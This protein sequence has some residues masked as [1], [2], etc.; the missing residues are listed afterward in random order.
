M[1]APNTLVKVYTA[2][3]LIML[4]LI[5]AAFFTPPDFPMLPRQIL[6]GVWGV[7][8]TLVAERWL[9]SRTWRQAG[10]AVGFVRTRLPAVAVA[11]LVSLP[12]WLFLPLLAWLQATPIQLQPDWFALLLGVMLVNGLTEE[13][14][15]RG[16][17]FGHLQQ[18]HSFSRAATLS[19]LLFAAQHLYLIFTIGWLAGLASVVLAAL[20]TFPLA[21]SY[22]RGGNSL[23]GPAILHTSSNAPMIILALPPSFG[24]SVLV[25]YMGVV[26]VSIYL[27]FILDRSPARPTVKAM[28]R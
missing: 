5:V 24:A 28:I 1:K 12:M 14:L 7:G 20:L 27:V 11:L 23:S 10:Q 26:L 16:F 9:F 3:I 8:A 6:L 25:P 4:P 17:V 21:Y 18:E 13:V 19:A 15:H 22:A 2:A